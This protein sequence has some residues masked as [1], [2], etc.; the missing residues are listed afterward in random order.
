M[1]NDFEYYKQLLIDAA[2]NPYVVTAKDVFDI[3]FSTNEKKN[4]LALSLLTEMTILWNTIQ[5]GKSSD[6]SQEL[7]RALV[8]KIVNSDSFSYED[9]SLVANSGSLFAVGC[10]LNNDSYPIDLLVEHVYLQDSE[11]NQ[12]DVSYFGFGTFQRMLDVTRHDRLKEV[13][14]YLREKI[15]GSDNMTDEMVLRISGVTVEPW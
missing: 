6:N 14:S 12:E 3:E 11:S 10:M 5:S 15:S 4:K 7:L 1:R 2:L 13:I 8:G 9:F